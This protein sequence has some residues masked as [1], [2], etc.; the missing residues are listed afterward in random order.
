MAYFKKS[1]TGK[2][3][4]GKYAKKGGGQKFSQEKINFKTT[5]SQCRKSCTVPFKPNGS[6]PVLCR[7]CFDGGDAGPRGPRK[8]HEKKAFKPKQAIGPTLKEEIKS[9]NKKLDR[10]LKLLEKDGLSF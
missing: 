7:D 3:G 8:H 10:I 9:I 6:K 5:C 1:G 2:R 4:P